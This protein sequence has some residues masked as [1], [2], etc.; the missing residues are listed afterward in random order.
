MY[1]LNFDN[2][3]LQFSCL[4]LFDFDLNYRVTPTYTHINIT[5]VTTHY[6]PYRAFDFSTFIKV[7]I[8]TS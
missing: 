1:A 7:I 8:H 6:D 4:V 3:V 2:T 5:P